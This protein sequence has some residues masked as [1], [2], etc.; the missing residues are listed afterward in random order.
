MDISQLRLFFGYS[1]LVNLGLF[2][3]YTLLMRFGKDTVFKYHGRW[4]NVSEEKFYATH[5]LIMQLHKVFIL[6]FNVVPWVVL[7]LLK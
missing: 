2:F 5:Y 7:G 4:T 1:A 6:F 3:L